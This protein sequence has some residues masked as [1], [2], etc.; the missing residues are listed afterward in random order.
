MTG[1]PESKATADLLLSTLHEAGFDDAH[2]E[3]YAIESRWQHARAVGRIVSPVARPL[4]IGS[5]GWVPGTK[6]E[7]TAPLVDLGAPPNNDL[8]VPADR[9]RG[10]AVIVDPH[11]DAI[12]A[13]LTPRATAS[14]QT[15][16]DTPRTTAAARPHARP[17]AGRT[18]PHASCG[19]AQGDR[20][21]VVRIPL[22]KLE[23]P[24]ASRDAI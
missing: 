8:P 19:A 22:R 16:A 11:S 13:I 2:V 10:A 17:R 1:S 15:P 7:V 12:E 4:A 24:V 9:V 3:E 18:A 20:K 6:G 21:E 23:G 5:Y 14:A